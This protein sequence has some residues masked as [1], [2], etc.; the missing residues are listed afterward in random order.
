MEIE[1]LGTRAKVEPSA[2]N[3]E[4][5]TGFLIDG[6]ILFDVGESE[7][8]DKEPRVIVFTHFHPDHAFFLYREEVFRPDVPHYG[9]E[10]HELIS[11]LEVITEKFEV[12]GYMIT[13]I[14]VIH[15]L[16]LKSFGY[17][18]EKEG[19]RV[20]ITGDVAWIEKQYL[21]E[22]PRV[23]LIITEATI[24]EKGGR[25]NRKEGRIYGHTGIP[26]LVRI[27]GPLSPRIVFTHFGDWFYQDVGK[28][29]GKLEGFSTPDTG[30]IPAY[31]GIRIKI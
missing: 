6:T 5:H 10:K 11:D 22:V 27:L 4:N 23:D 28:S 1:I 20:F 16:R 21:K 8:L 24:I 9:P 12:E 26:D 2:P 13:P 31:D 7:F 25:T 30:I 19:E 18:I 3:Y 15:A 17:V 14:P 29:P